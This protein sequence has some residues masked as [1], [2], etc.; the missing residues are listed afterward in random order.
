MNASPSIIELEHSIFPFKSASSTDS[1]NLYVLDNNGSY[2][3]K[4]P[5]DTL[6]TSY[7]LGSET[8]SSIAVTPD[9]TKVLVTSF[10]DNQIDALN[11]NTLAIL[12]SGSLNNKEIT[13]MVVT[14]DNAYA[15]LAA[16]S[17]ESA[18]RYQISN[19][20]AT[21]TEITIGTYQNSIAITPDGSQ[22]LLLTPEGNGLIVIDSNTLTPTAVSIP[23]PG[24]VSI[25]LDSAKAYITNDDPSIYLVSL[26]NLA[27]GPTTIDISNSGGRVRFVT[28][29][30]I[31]DDPIP[32]SDPVSDVIYQNNQNSPLR[33]Q[34]NVRL[35]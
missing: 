35:K 29:A 28:I 31:V 30:T 34:R 15:F 23:E 25:T 20:S 32:P 22:V 3:V 6:T 10:T 7:A 9:G 2:I 14:P 13:D 4:I 19:L 27:A 17:S 5:F 24:D 33:F 18:Y 8:P 1:Q 21:P 11:P 12:S 16:S 26:S